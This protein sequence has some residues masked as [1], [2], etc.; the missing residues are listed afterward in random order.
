MKYSEASK[1]IKKLSDDYSTNLSTGYSVYYKGDLV[2]Y[3]STKEMY[4]IYPS[5]YSIYKLPYGNKLWMILS[6]LAMTKPSDRLSKPK[7]NVIIGKDGPHISTVWHKVNDSFPI[8]P[9]E[10]D[11]ISDDYLTMPQYIFTGEEYLSLI[12]Y[13]KTLPD[14]EFQVMVANHGKALVRED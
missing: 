6:E 10:I 2:V 9:Y 8:S 4:G 14:C 11:T 13:I 1:L 3:V 12:K 7:Y 5:N